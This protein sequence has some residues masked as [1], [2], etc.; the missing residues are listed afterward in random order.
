MIISIFSF[1]LIPSIFFL[2][3]IISLTFTSCKSKILSNII[4]SRF[5]TSPLLFASKIAPLK[6]CLQSL[7]LVSLLAK[8][9]I[10]LTKRCT[11]KFIGDKI[12]VKIFIIGEAY[13][14]NFSGSLIA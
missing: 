4:R 11:R 7:F 1:I 6:F 13:N 8:F 14:T 5:L 2:W 12:I 3:V 10:E 9:R